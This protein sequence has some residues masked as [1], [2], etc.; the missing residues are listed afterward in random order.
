MIPP[1]TGLLLAI[2][3]SPIASIVVKATVTVCLALIG[4]WVAPRSRAAVRHSLLLAAF[5]VLLLL[6]VASIVGP[7][8]RI[9]VADRAA[10]TPELSL[11]DVTLTPHA[12]SEHRGI[13]GETRTSSGI[14]L[15]ALVMP[16]WGL[17]T[18]LSLLPMAIGWWRV[19][20]LRRSALPWRVGKPP[21]EALAIECG[22]ERNIEV[23]L[24]EA[25]PGPMTCGVWRPAIVLPA[26]AHA[27]A[28]DDLNRALMHELEHVRRADCVIHCLARLAC[29]IYWFHPLVWTAWRKLGLEAE[30]ACDDAVLKRSEAAAYAD[31]LLELA[32]RLSM[33][34]HAPLYPAMAGRTDL[35]KRIAAL[36]D[37]RQRRGR[38]SA[39]VVATVFAFAAGLIFALSP[40]RVVAAPQARDTAALEFNAV[41]VKLVDT[42]T[43][44]RHSDEESDPGRLSIG[45]N[46]H[47]FIIRAYGITDQQIGGE[48]EWFKTHL[49]AIE[50]VTT[51][52][53]TL[54]Q[55]MLMLRNALADRFQLKLHQEERDLPVYALQVAPSGPK[56]RELKPGEG[57]DRDCTIRTPGIYNQCFLSIEDL[58][59]VLNRAFGGPLAVDRPVVDRTNLTGRYNAHL[60]TARQSEK[61]DSGRTTS[62][63][64]LF[65]DIQS[66]MGL[67]LVPEKVK[68][69]YYAVEH[70]IPATPN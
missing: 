42:A 64:D 38:A 47:R 69:P 30:R 51:G 52:P 44:E 19:R 8:V 63:P 36:L 66:Q 23:L 27:W 43:G 31:Q 34:A 11:D 61:D 5:S 46:L 16:L 12:T 6:P 17:G 4:T 41:S 28:A 22:I 35:A 21:V 25:A 40:L 62:F 3:G 37:D 68:M 1:L 10:V 7:P 39:L 59:N 60:R 48:P 49:Y 14:S 65:H 26:G 58:T 54:S 24:H 2:S 55:K 57:L 45:G 33:A 50:A 15:S 56:F 70:A 18:A 53:A 32:R 13:A 29:A 67:K 20:D 9:A